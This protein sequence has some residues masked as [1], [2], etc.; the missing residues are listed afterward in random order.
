MERMTPVMAAWRQLCP[1]VFGLLCK[2]QVGRKAKQRDNERP[3]QNDG[4]NP[5]VQLRITSL[6]KRN[7]ILS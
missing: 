1:F 4:S 6:A 2:V 5:P 3:S 7:V